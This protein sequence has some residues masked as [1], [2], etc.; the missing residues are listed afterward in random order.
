[1][2]LVTHLIWPHDL[3]CQDLPLM[4]MLSLQRRKKGVTENIDKE[5]YIILSFEYCRVSQMR[6]RGPCSC[7]TSCDLYPTFGIARG[8][9]KMAIFI[10]ST[11]HATQ[12]LKNCKVCSGVWVDCL[13]HSSKNQL[14]R[15]SA[16][17]KTDNCGEP[18]WSQVTHLPDF[19]QE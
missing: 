6:L 4:C 9:Q 7:V 14:E 5:K 15:N 16:S 19:Y 2:L 8:R 10:I 12:E 13:C 1:M 18:M 3:N 11:T 17:I